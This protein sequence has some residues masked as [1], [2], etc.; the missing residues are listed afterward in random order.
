MKEIIVSASRRTDLVGWYPERLVKKI[1]CIKEEVE[2]DPE[3][4][5][6]GTV[7]WTRFPGNILN[8][9]PLREF[10]KNEKQPI[11]INFTLTGLGGTKW[12]PRSPPVKKAIDDLKQVIKLL[13]N[14]PEKIMWRFDPLLKI[15]DFMETYER[16]EYISEKIAKLGIKKCIISFPA[17]VSLK[18]NLIN[19]YKRFGILLWTKEEKIKLLRLMVDKAEKLGLSLESCNQPSLTKWFPQI[20]PAQCINKELLERFSPLKIKLEL[21]K[22]PSQRRFCNCPKSIDIGSYIEEP[23]GSGCVYC[24]SRAG[25]LEGKMSWEEKFKQLYIPAEYN[26]KGGD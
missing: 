15:K 12:E 11:I 4:I 1:Y 19:R 18:G 20:K 22:D 26:Q 9:K 10:V 8:V 21:P 24:Y 23:C 5:Y 6:Y 7:L 13:G 14:E 17:Y 3:K 2:K 25:G 16:F